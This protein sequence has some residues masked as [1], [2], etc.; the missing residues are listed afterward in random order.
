MPTKWHLQDH[1]HERA[2]L[3]SMHLMPRAKGQQVALKS[4]SSAAAPLYRPWFAFAQSAPIRW[5][6]HSSSPAAARGLLRRPCVDLVP[7]PATRGL[8]EC[9]HPGRAVLLRHID[10]AIRGVPS[11]PRGPRVDPEPT[12]T[13]TTTMTVRGRAAPPHP[14]VFRAKL[15]VLGRRPGP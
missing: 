4:P 14:R 11:R 7:E 2:F 3:R 1:H 10:Q 13:T 15:A 9:L 6:T 8:P 12:D 5:K